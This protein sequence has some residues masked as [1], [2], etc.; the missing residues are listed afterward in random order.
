MPRAIAARWIGLI[1]M[2]VLGVSA[3]KWPWS[4]SAIPSG[5]VNPERPECPHSW[6]RLM[7]PNEKQHAF[8]V[9]T[10]SFPNGFSVPRTQTNV[11][12]F[13]DCQKFIIKD[14]AGGRL[15]Y[16]PSLMAVFASDRLD[17][18][19]F[20]PPSDSVLA[21]AEVLNYSTTFVYPA[22]GIKPYFN[23]LYVYGAHGQLRAK[24]FPVGVDEA[25]CQKGYPPTDIPGH[26]L[27]VREMHIPGFDK[28]GDYPAVAR[29]DWDA[30]NSVQYIGLRC[31]NAWCEIGPGTPEDA[32]T[33][34]FT[35]SAPYATPAFASAENR[36]RSIKG[37]YDEQLLAIDSAGES[38]STLLRGT[39]FPDTSLG[40]LTM[41]DLDGQWKAVSHIALHRPAPGTLLK[42]LA[43][44]KAKFNLDPISP[45]AA[46]SEMNHVLLC[47]GTITS[48]QL[49][50]PATKSMKTSCGATA[51][52]AALTTKRY[53]AQIT[54]T[55]G[56]SMYRCM[57]PHAHAGV[58]APGTA[59]WRWL[60]RD[61]TSWR[62]CP[63][64]CCEVN[65]DIF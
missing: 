41:P 8:P 64:G 60:A 20:D 22:L 54:T 31:G 43:I 56:T 53:W 24:M 17:S 11:P 29:W 39:I 57:T 35:S 3:C 27:A 59:R 4:K 46:L 26:E 48:C 65:G 42:E 10:M 50:Q 62:W 32:S 52:N 47:Y 38:R 23:C 40:T 63:A 51:L 37:W 25:L 61:E 18:I 1:L 45:G 12:E 34:A 2:A 6:A 21:A 58:M 14:P 15:T 44:Y 5:M 9:P 36:V 28:P 55:L 19:S 33:P 16:G 13:N 7:P 30:R 49:P